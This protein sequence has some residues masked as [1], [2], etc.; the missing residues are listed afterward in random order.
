MN[1]PKDGIRL[2]KSNFASI[3]QQLQPLLAN[4]DCYRLIIRPW[5]ETRSLS[6]NAL[7][8][9]WFAEIS[10]YLIKRGK[11]FASP[12]WVKDALKH[13]YLGYERREMTDV[14]TGEKTIISSLRHTSELDTGEMHFFL[15]QVEAWA[16]SI[17]CRLTIPEDCE[18][19]QLRAEQEA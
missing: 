7:A 9:M 3:G 19:A 12:A 16:L 18:Y 5:R 10:D 1:F 13:S 17:G 4:G 11:S 14:I 8:H 15:S 2:H 6:Q